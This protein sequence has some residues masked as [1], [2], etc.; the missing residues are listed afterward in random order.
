MKA[1]Q[2][3]SHS[4]LL[5]NSGEKPKGSDH[6]PAG[7]QQVDQAR[8]GVA[9]EGHPVDLANRFEVPRYFSAN[10]KH[11]TSLWPIRKARHMLRCN[12]G[13]RAGQQRTPMPVDPHAP[14]HC[15]CE[16]GQ[17]FTVV[18]EEQPLGRRWFPCPS[19]GAPKISP[20]A[21]LILEMVRECVC[22][23]RIHFHLA[24]RGCAPEWMEHRLIEDDP[25]TGVARIRLPGEAECRCGHVH[26]FPML[27]VFWKDA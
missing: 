24:P 8:F 6:Q 18:C 14:V 5:A 22:G 13:E 7:P 2:E 21:P 10:L 4:R 25:S 23:R 9:T 20:H 16:C 17:E 27:V 26:R 19:C 12:A 1:S 11:A 15:A 3:Y